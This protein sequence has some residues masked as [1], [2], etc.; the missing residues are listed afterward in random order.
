MKCLVFMEDKNKLLDDLLNAD[1]ITKVHET[2]NKLAQHPQ[3]D[4][5]KLMTIMGSM[6]ALATA[7]EMGVIPEDIKQDLVKL[8][9]KTK[10]EF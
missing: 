6:G 10:K 7:G 2:F 8:M 3:V 9:N 1:S 5:F 4:P